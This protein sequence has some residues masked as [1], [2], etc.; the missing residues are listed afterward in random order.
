MRTIKMLAVA[1]LLG[2]SATRA[3]EAVDRTVS[4]APD[5]EVQIENVAGSVEVEAWDRSEIRVVAD[6]GDDVENLAIEVDGDEVRIEVEIPDHEGRRQHWDIDSDVQVWIPSRASVDIET[7]SASV[8]VAG[9]GGTLEVETVSGQI[10]AEGSPASAELATVS[11]NIDFTGSGTAIDAE[12]VSGHIDLEGVT[13]RIDV[14]TVSGSVEVDGSAIERADFESVSGSIKLSADLVRGA[15]VDCST[16]SGNVE[17][18]LP[19]NTAASFEVETFAGDISSD[20][21]GEVRRTSRYAPGR[22]LYHSTG[23]DAKISVETF[24]GRVYLIKD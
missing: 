4:V 24:S 3:G 23:S 13:G 18:L 12:T 6:L 11:G 10:D 7:V 17:L 20:F 5:V 8:E 1:V 14:S 2:A 21:G 22:E 19:A 9:V 15:R 16:H